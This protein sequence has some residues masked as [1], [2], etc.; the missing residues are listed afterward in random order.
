MKLFAGMFTPKAKREYDLKIGRELI[1]AQGGL[2]RIEAVTSSPE[3]LEGGRPSFMIENETHLWYKNNEGHEMAQ[4]A[5]RNAG[6]VGGRVMAITNAPQTG[7]DS[8]AERDRRA[9]DEMV[10]TSGGANFRLMYDSLEV[11]S[12]APMLPEYLPILI[13]KVRG[14][15]YWYKID[16]VVNEILDPRTPTSQS[17]RFYFNQILSVEDALIAAYEWDQCLDR[18]KSLQPGDEIVLGLDP[19]KT[20]DAT[21]LVAIRISDRFICPLKIWEI[22]QGPLG[23]GK[24]IDFDD[25]TNEIH[26]AFETYKVRAFFSD[27]NPV[28]GYVD[29]W[30]DEYREKLLIK[31]SMKSTV[32]YDMRGNQREI[33]QMNE[34]LV[35]ALRDKSVSHNQPPGSKLREHALNAYQ[36]PKAFGEETGMSFRKESRESARKVDGWAATVLAYT[37][38]NRYLDSGKRPAEEP[39]GSF[40]LF[41]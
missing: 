40:H 15:S 27:V 41:Y 26:N 5:K 33:M 18:E 6:K 31:A 1:H 7:M 29:M 14:D 36:W 9:Y 13:D 38:L 21:A 30:S 11:P 37:A 3:T 28:Q 25:V 34:A 2:G 22:P 16:E 4:V 35:G 24:E 32:G 39:D 17:R 8:V 23:V 19:S 20:D 10:S 12:D